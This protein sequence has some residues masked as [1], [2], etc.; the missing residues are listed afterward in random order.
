MENQIDYK[1][2]SNLRPIDDKIIIKKE[3]NSRVMS[4]GVY[5]PEQTKDS[6]IGYIVAVGPGQRNFN[7]A[8]DRKLLLEQKDYLENTDRYPMMC[9]VGD[10][11][12]YSTIVGQRI[13]VDNDELII[14]RESELLYIV[15]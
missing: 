11:V 5:L 2:Y 6:N 4:G 14:Q 12:V 13:V 9:K 1:K 3:D 8:S 15:K 10:K 7:A